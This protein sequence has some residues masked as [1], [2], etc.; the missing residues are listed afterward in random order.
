MKTICL[1]TAQEMKELGCPQDSKFYWHK[2]W[3]GCEYTL[4]IRHDN[5]VYEL[6]CDSCIDDRSVY[7]EDRWHSAYISDEILDKLPEYL[8]D[9][10]ETDLVRNTFP[11]MILRINGFY[12][13]T[14]RTKIGRHSFNNII[15]SDKNLANALL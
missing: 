10:E 3:T 4:Y 13:V 6:P 1:K 11:L 5:T 2:K 9:G 15:I 12:N 8:E 14:Y 7:E